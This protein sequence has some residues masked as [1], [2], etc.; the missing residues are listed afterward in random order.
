MERAAD[1]SFLRK[2]VGKIRTA[3]GTRAVH[4][5]ISS[6]P[7]FVSKP[8]F[9]TGRVSPKSLT[10]LISVVSNSETAAMGSQERRSNSTIGFI[11]PTSVNSTFLA[12]SSTPPRLLSE[13]LKTA[14]RTSD[15]PRQRNLCSEGSSALS[16]RLHWIA[17]RRVVR[18]EQPRRIRRPPGF[19]T[20]RVQ[21]ESYRA[22]ELSA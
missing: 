1:P 8:F 6:T 21:S 7:V 10:P 4:Q 20:A 18:V 22:A 16:H 5:A 3:L 9:I 11:G 15:M 17:I 2:S 12:L 14:V 13:P 19:S